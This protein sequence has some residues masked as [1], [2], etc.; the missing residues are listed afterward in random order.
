MNGSNT[1]RWGVKNAKSPCEV[2][3]LPHEESKRKLHFFNALIFASQPTSIGLPRLWEIQMVCQY[4]LAFSFPLF[5]SFL[6]RRSSRNGERPRR[7][8]LQHRLL[9][10]SH[11]TWEGRR[12]AKWRKKEENRRRKRPRRQR[13]IFGGGFPLSFFKVCSV[14]GTEERLHQRV[15]GAAEGLRPMIWGVQSSKK[16]Y[17]R[18]PIAIHTQSGTDIIFL[19][20]RLL[21]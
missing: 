6:R 11:R 13:W 19:K 7:V 18:R 21:L 10:P 5:L 12:E 2:L 8:S 20:D 16:L 1:Q 9:R 17:F 14:V 3:L 4:S 15:R